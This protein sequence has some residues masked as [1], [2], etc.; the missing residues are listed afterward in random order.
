MRTTLVLLVLLAVA[1]GFV[2]GRR[3]APM[4]TLV[5]CDSVWPDPITDPRDPYLRHVIP[6]GDCVLGPSVHG[7]PVEVRF[8]D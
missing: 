2:L 5:I 7:S 6:A 1:L 8:I 4:P 3:F